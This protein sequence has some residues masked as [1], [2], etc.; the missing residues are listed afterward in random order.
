MKNQ[1]IELPRQQ[2]HGTFV[3]PDFSP[4]IPARIGQD[5][6]LLKCLAQ[7]SLASNAVGVPFPEGSFTTLEE[8]VTRQ[9]N[10]YLQATLSWEGQRQLAGNIEI[11]VSAEKL[12]MRVAALPHGLCVIM[13]KPVIE[14]LEAHQT[15]LGW[16]VLERIESASY[17]GMNIY[18]PRLLGH[19]TCGYLGDNYTDE[20]FAEILYEEE[21]GEEFKGKV[22]PKM[23][24]KC[25]ESWQHFPSDVLAQVDGHAHLLGW[26]VKAEDKKKSS[27]LTHKQVVA[28]AGTNKLTK[29]L[30]ECVQAA[31]ELDKCLSKK[32]ACDVYFGA[33]HDIDQ[34][35]GEQ[36]DGIGT[37]CFMAWED[38]DMLIEMVEHF[39]RGAYESGT[40][41][42]YLTMAFVDFEATMDEMKIMARGMRAYIKRWNALA[43]LV[44]CFPL[45]EDEE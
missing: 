41:C 1:L 21:N 17:R 27:A 37:T 12:E 45:I 42:E 43:R 3:L 4:N 25:R 40:A 39:E 22:T 7:F 24:A 5:D 26:K 18:G 30:Q 15:G 9:W 36:M 10:H 8:T 11:C 38:H 32:S 16:Y 35:D 23:I 29:E 2:C 33:I 6:E 19:Q 13:L 34:M 31:I 44:A 14:A 20:E 28:I